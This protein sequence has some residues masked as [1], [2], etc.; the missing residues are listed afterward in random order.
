M[1]KHHE[2]EKYNKPSRIPDI[3]YKAYEVQINKSKV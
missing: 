3:N 1:I 2:Q